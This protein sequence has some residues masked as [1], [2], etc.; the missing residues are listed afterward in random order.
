MNEELMCG[1]KNTGCHKCGADEITATMKY[2][3][4]EGGTCC[5]HLCSECD[6]DFIRNQLSDKARKELGWKDDVE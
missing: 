5:I 4:A 6:D 1:C 3:N 2:E